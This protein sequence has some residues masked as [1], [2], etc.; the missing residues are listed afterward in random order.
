[1]NEQTF[2]F[3][4]DINP[5]KVNPL[6]FL[7]K[8]LSATIITKGDLTLPAKQINKTEH[9][10]KPKNYINLTWDETADTSN[11]GSKYWP[12]QNFGP[13]I[14]RYFSNYRPILADI[15]PHHR[16]RYHDLKPCL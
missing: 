2:R 13:P 4:N 14:P 5:T 16:N 3:G 7:P 8:H 12:Y 10:N 9:V 15:G 6:D 1:M 11:Q